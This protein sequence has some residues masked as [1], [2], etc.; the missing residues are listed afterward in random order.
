MVTGASAG[1]G[2]AT[3]KAFA[4]RGDRV[5][6]LARGRAGLE[7]AAAEVRAAGGTALAIEADVADAAAVDAGAARVEEELGPIDVWINNAMTAVLAEVRQ[8]SPEEFRRVME[9]TFLGT[10]HGTLSALRRMQARDS[11]AIVQVGSA[12]ARRGIPLQAT[13]CAA[14][15]ATQG[16]VESLRSELIH[17]NSSVRLAIVQL[18]AHNTPQFG[19]VRVR[20]LD[21]HPQPVPPI[22]QPEVAAKAIVWASEH[23]RKE[24]WVGW[25]TAK[26][27][28]GNWFVPRYQDRFLARNG[29]DD[30]Q[31]AG[32]PLSPDREDYLFSPVDDDRDA[33]THGIFDDRSRD[34]SVHLWLNLHRRAL[35]SAGAAGLAGALAGAVAARR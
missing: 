2:R 28:V 6:L 21:G 3:A 22:F 25:P 12:L 18:P 35:V 11:G 1:I 33:G 30:Q 17:Q 32:S 4:A 16:F 7:A 27:I 13:Y 9:V 29:Y 20:G 19:W 8:T 15:H 14:K 34:R 5:A 24:L 31:M 23:D 10:V 26:A